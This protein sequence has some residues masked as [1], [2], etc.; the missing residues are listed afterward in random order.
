MDKY[1]KKIAIAI[2]VIGIILRVFYISYTSIEDRQHD[3]KGRFGHLDYYDTI[4]QTGKLPND[5]NGQFYHPPL[6]YIIGAGFLKIQ[7]EIGIEN[8]QAKE[9]L[10]ILTTIYSA[11]ILITIYLILNK[12][13]IK[14]IYK[15]IILL[16]MAVH[17]TF[18]I[19]SGSIN[20]DVL[21]IMFETL[22]IL[23]LIK[24]HEKSSIKNTIIL[25]IFTAA[26][27]LTKVSTII[28]GLPIAIVFLNKFILEMCRNK[29][30]IQVLKTYIIRFLIFGLISIG[31]GFLYIIRNMILFDQSILYVLKVTDKYFCGDASFIERFSLFSPEWIQETYCNS[32]IE[33]NMFAWIVRCSVFGEYTDSTG[34]YIVLAQVLKWTNAILIFIGIFATIRLFIRQF[35]TNTKKSQGIDFE[36]QDECNII[37]NSITREIFLTTYLVMIIA[38]I[39]GNL[40]MPYGCTMDFRYIPL[41]AFL[42]FSFIM[43]DL[44]DSRG[45]KYYNVY[46]YV[47]YILTAIFVVL[48]VIEIFTLMKYLKLPFN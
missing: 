45:K 39:Y 19:L 27:L 43:I 9:N 21:S 16:V 28:M 14:K 47:V 5:N 10:Q 41:T 26:A 36:K 20:N 11:I 7:E 46:K 32:Q 35:F 8:S 40:T 13:N 30:K 4:Y 15:L 23:Y 6:N 48:S 24:W 3:M 34:N 18:I 42:G 22:I 2:I 25:G 37:T 29:N 12:L 33:S 1:Y 17:P 38:Y 31:I 44:F